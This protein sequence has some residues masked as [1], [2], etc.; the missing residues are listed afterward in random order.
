MKNHHRLLHGLLGLSLLLLL[1]AQTSLPR[2]EVW[3]T[4][5]SSQQEIARFTVEIA[6]TPETW[7]RGLME[8]ASLDPNAGMLFIFPDISPRAF[9]MMNTL[10]PLD[11]LFID[12]TRRVIN[13]QEN[14]L[15]C[16]APR[17]CPT[18]NSTAPAKY[19]LEIPGGRARALGLQAGDQVHF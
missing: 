14:A 15:P 18:Y 1:S 5:G 17:R 4:G 10:I 19:V 7:E 12:A 3:I 13:I 6:E 9:W 2:K 8:R 11:M 16:A